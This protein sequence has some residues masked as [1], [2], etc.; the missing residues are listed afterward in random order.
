MRT[1]AYIGVF[2]FLMFFALGYSYFYPAHSPLS[3]Q[4]WFTGTVVPKLDAWLVGGRQGTYSGH[5]LSGSGEL[6]YKSDSDF[7][8]YPVRGSQHFYGKT[9]ISSGVN[10]VA[11]VEVAE[12]VQVQLESNSVLVIEPQVEGVSD[13]PIVRVIGG[14]V[15]AKAKSGSV[16]KVRVVAANGQSRVID[17]RGVAVVSDGK[18]YIGEVPENLE[19]LRES[20]ASQDEQLLERER[21]VR[22]ESLRAEALRAQAEAEAAAAEKKIVDFSI[23]EADSMRRSPASNVEQTTSVVIP[24]KIPKRKFNS[25]LAGVAK[26]EPKTEVAKGIY[27]AKRGMKA[28]ATRSFAS[29]LSSPLYNANESF[30]PSVQLALDG[31][32]ESYEMNKRCSLA[33]DTLANAKK[34]YRGDSGAQ[35]WSAAWTSRLANGR[36]K[37][38]K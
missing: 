20:Y 18:G 19:N 33:R 25:S 9:M 32:L 6:K 4:A 3:S 36:C 23:T 21:L 5:L 34:Q 30:G 27:Q 28:E 31:M 2:A 35:E 10:S 11:T 22:E 1:V 29:A 17:E 26:E 38:V 15:V 37:N 12:G 24:K 13:G 16:Q 14:A 7:V 8:F